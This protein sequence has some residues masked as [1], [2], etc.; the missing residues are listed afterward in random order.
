MLSEGHRIFALKVLAKVMASVFFATSLTAI[1]DWKAG[2][3][4]L[5]SEWPLFVAIGLL[6]GGLFIALI[7]VL[8]NTER[9]RRETPC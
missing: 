1:L 8:R 7:S 6:S 3:I 9:H 5:G 4:L 2:S